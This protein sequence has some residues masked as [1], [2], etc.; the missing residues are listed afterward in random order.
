M[1]RPTTTEAAKLIRAELKASFPGIKFSVRSSVYS[2]GSSIDVRWTMG[3]TEKAVEAIVGKY[4]DGYFDGMDDSYK[5]V[6]GRIGGAKHVTVD[7]DIPS[8]IYDEC[9]AAIAALYSYDDDQLNRSTRETLRATDLTRGY[10]GV[11]FAGGEFLIMPPARAAIVAVDESRLSV[12]D[13]ALL[14]A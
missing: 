2:M 13:L 11:V 12:F 14:V 7:R 5:C 4:Q 1:T 8:E 6:E 3:P 10:G 9:R